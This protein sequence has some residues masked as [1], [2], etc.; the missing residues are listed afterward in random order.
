MAKQ[1]GQKRTVQ[2]AQENTWDKAF[3]TSLRRLGNVTVACEAARISRSAVYERR[4]N[5]E[6]F[7][8]AWDEA[9]EEASDRLELEA[10]RRA[11]RGT[12]KPIYQK[13]KRVGYVREYSDTLMS[14]LLKGNR[15]EKFA[16]RFMLKIDPK[17]AAFLEK[18][19]MT[20]SQAWDLLMQ[21]LHGERADG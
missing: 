2:R 9:L 10:R 14:L 16:E 8:D 1:A 15:P 4:K 20:I 3:L 18:L 17:D 21:E 11:E 7:S 19:G 6:A 13:G 12:L 5:D